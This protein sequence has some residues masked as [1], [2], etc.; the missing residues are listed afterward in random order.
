MAIAKVKR[1]LLD[2]GLEMEGSAGLL[3]GNI[4]DTLMAHKFDILGNTC[5]CDK[6]NDY[7]W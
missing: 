5:H 6:L 1:F 3:P 2:S 7:D 4:L